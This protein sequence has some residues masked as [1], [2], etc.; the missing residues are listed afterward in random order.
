MW[1]SQ[2]QL[3]A[4]ELSIKLA[5]EDWPS[6]PLAVQHWMH[7]GKQSAVESP[8][9]DDALAGFSAWLE[10]KCTLREL[11]RKN[12]KQRVNVFVNSVPNLTVADVRPETIEG[13]LDKRNI[14]MKSR[15]NDRRAIS[16][17][18]SWCIERPRRW[19]A[20]NP[21]REV[22]V[23]KEEAGAPKILS[24]DECGALLRAAE[25]QHS[26]TLAPYTAVCLFAGLRPFEAARLTWEQVN[27]D[28]DEI[29]LEGVQTKTGKPRVIQICPT[30]KKW[31][32]A[33]K[34]T[35]HFP[36]NWRKHFDT[37]KAAAGFGGRGN[38][39]GESNLK[40]WPVD[41]LRHTAIS[42]YF[43]KTGSY[44]QTAEQFGNS[45]SIIKQHYQGRVSS[46]D[47]K[48]FYGLNPRKGGP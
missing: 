23:E 3:Q 42:H 7:H 2:E 20:M 26:G 19:A 48:R 41:V 36:P 28:D 18:F 8:R 30:L 24:V 27:L 46:E 1:L 12:L 38:G 31:L 47:T 29:R 40:P 6:L 14:S 4:A 35:E 25:I 9:L 15:D 17:F 5:G 33:Y 16:R 21:C 43:R 13:F 44:G 37:I 22:R 45:E 10:T 39:D 32:L 34:G 11:S